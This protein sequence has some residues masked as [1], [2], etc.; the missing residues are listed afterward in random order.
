MFGM[1]QSLKKDTGRDN[2]SKLFKAAAEEFN[3]QSLDQHTIRVLYQTQRTTEVIALPSSKTG[4]VILSQCMCV[5]PLLAPIVRHNRVK[6]VC[7]SIGP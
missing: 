6:S 2:L 4:G 5:Y 7:D 3:L 1:V